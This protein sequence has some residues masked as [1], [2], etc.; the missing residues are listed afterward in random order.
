M[1][2]LPCAGGGGKLTPAVKGREVLSPGHLG[3]D[4]NIQV[5]GERNG[6]VGVS[7][8]SILCPISLSSWRFYFML[9]VEL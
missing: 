7:G 5:T 8:H 9:E 4:V 3:V 6:A 2:G 1:H